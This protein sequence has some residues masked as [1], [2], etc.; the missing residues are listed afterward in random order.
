[1]S[2]PVLWFLM[3]LFQASA[4]PVTRYADVP[5][6]S[7]GFWRVF[8]A[9]LLL[10]PGW[11]RA[12]RAGP[13]A[14]I[15][16][17]GAA[18]TGFFLG[19]H[20]ATWCWA[21]QHTT[22]ANAVLFVGM[23][24]VLTPFLGRWMNGDRLTT[25]ELGGTAAACGGMAWILGGQILL[26]PDHLPGSLMALASMVCCAFYLVLGRRHRSPGSIFLFSVPVYASAAATQAVF[27][28]A[29]DGGLFTGDASTRMALAALALV[30]TV[31]GHTLAL[32]LLRRTTAHVIALS[33]P[34]QFVL[35]TIVAVPL[36]A[37]RPAVWFYP[38]AALV[39]AGVVAAILAPRRPAPP[40]LES[41]DAAEPET[42][43]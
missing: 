34:A 22:I 21:L 9:A 43:H 42:N 25:R 32:L 10:A 39:T 19:A 40:G 27:A 26:T 24:P 37:E 38:G 1:M 36:F 28:L 23:Q 31:G 14:P 3:M 8:G 18:L 2:T 33:V 16:P 7:I 6:S 13:G 20:F 11:A 4:A 12:R 15:L 35:N 5:A 17:R 41:A 29:L 30:P